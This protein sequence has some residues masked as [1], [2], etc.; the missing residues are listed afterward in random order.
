[1][2]IVNG[3]IESYKDWIRTQHLEKEVFSQLV[4]AYR[5]ILRCGYYHCNLSTETVLLQLQANSS[6]P[7]SPV[8]VI[9]LAGFEQAVPISTSRFI[10]I[11]GT[12]KGKTSFIAPEVGF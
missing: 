7:S 3:N 11:D 10:P 6:L 5:H 4:D 8:I 1:M 2:E 12:C 9:K